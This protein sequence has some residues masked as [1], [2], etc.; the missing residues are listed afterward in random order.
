[1]KKYKAVIIDGKK[2][3]KTASS[4]LAA[5]ALCGIVISAA[6]SESSPLSL[7]NLSPEGIISDVL[8]AAGAAQN[9]ESAPS[10]ILSSIAHILSGVNLNNPIEIVNAEIPVFS[11]VNQSAAAQLADDSIYV[12][13][14]NGTIPESVLAENIPSDIPEENRAPIKGANLSPN[15]NGS[16]KISIGNET[17]Y[18]VDIDEMLSS[19]P[20]IDMSQNG[21]KVLVIHTHATEAYSPNGSSV[22]DT[23]KGDRSTDKNQNVIKA[24]DALCD[25]LNKKGVE[26]IHDTELHDYPSFNGAYAHSLSAIENYIK[27]YPS[28]QIVFDVHRDSIVYEDKTKIKSVTEINGKTAAQ[29]MLVVGTDQNGLE[30][31]NWRERLKTAIHFQNEINKRYPTLMR[32]INLRK[33]RFNGHAANGSMIIETGTGGNSLEEA[34]YGIS[35]AAD[36]IGDY[37]KGL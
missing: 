21:P 19:P 9:T 30:N 15:K 32:H 8:P 25:I 12:H 5:G 28:I 29:L 26:T 37:L 13:S 3:I 17:D 20:A 11:A 14:Y 27:K 36:C 23:E 1:M 33:E 34:I 24:G 2:L 7:F 18:S 35:L 10:K 6:F 31:P 16:A 22:Y 4:V